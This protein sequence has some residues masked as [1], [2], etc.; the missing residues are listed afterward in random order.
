[1]RKKNYITPG[2]EIEV[3]DMEDVI[4]TSPPNSFEKGDNDY[5]NSELTSSIGND[6]LNG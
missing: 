2:M 1:M 4:V 6:F 5:T 3:F